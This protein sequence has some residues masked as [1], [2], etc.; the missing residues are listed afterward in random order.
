M[1]TITFVGNIGRV[2]DLKDTGKG[3]VLDFSVAVNNSRDKQADP[4]WIDCSIWGPRAQALAQYLAKGKKVCVIGEHA[5]RTYTKDGRDCFSEECKVS[6]MEFFDVAKREGGG[7]GGGYSGGQQSG[8]S[9]GNRGGGQQGGGYG[10]GSGGGGYSDAD[11]G[12]QGG[13]SGGQ[14]LPF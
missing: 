14:G 7:S 4:D 10:S 13:E 1:K 12:D 8:G 2:R 3:I 5:I 11:Y 6:E 9:S